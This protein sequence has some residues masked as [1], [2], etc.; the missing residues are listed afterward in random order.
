MVQTPVVSVT[1]STFIDRDNKGKWLE[2]YRHADALLVMMETWRALPVE[3]LKGDEFEAVRTLL[4]F[5]MASSG[6]Y[7]DA[8]QT[9]QTM[10]ELFAI[11]KEFQGWA[12][13]RCS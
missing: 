1:S 11:Q 3:R 13:T 7:I 9:A 10:E 5:L 8:V 2:V 12:R 4:S 6:H